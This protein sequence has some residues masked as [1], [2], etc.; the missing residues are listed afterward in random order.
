MIGPDDAYKRDNHVSHE[1]FRHE[2][3]EFLGWLELN[4]QDHF[5]I[6]TGDRHWHY[7]SVHT[8][9]YEEFACGALN[10]ENARLG[11]NPG[12]PQSTDPQALVK[13]LY[14]DAKPT[15]GFLLVD[16]TPPT[17]TAGATLRF[18]VRDEQGTELYSATKQAPA[19]K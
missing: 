14:T 15:G 3:E 5:Y 13:Q 2:G 8:S 9:G 17:A 12:D 11:R 16:V 1:G 19:R 4:R 6:L 10:V 7:H 18:S